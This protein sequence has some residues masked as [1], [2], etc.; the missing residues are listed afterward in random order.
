MTGCLPVCIGNSS[1]IIE[2]MHFCGKEYVAVAE[3]HKP[4]EQEKLCQTLKLF[5]GE[6][7]QRPPLRSSVV[8]K[9]RKRTIYYIDKIEAKDRRLLLRIG[10]ESGTYIR[11]LIHDIG[12]VLG[13]GAHMAELRRTRDGVLEESSSFTLYDVAEALQEF[14][15]KKDESKIRK[16]V[17]P[18]EEALAL[19]P[20]V[21]VKDSAVDAI[22]HGASVA[23]KGISKLDTP[24]SEKEPIV[25][26]SLRGEC[27]ALGR[28]MIS[29][30][31]ILSNE[32][33]IAVKTRRVVMDPGTYPRMWRRH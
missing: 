3:I 10:C 11:K 17:R 21:Y 19:L 30:E 4:V 6:I 33:G 13:V 5:V 8:R 29:S 1:K 7:Y 20:S 9:V 28:A 27:V 26:K 25:I 24:F 12:I 14:S 2:Y 15:E 18:M 16:V 32:S 22:C 31:R 23:I